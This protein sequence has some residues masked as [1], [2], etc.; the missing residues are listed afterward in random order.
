MT[1]NILPS[2][3]FKPAQPLGFGK[4]LRSLAVAT[5]R[6]IVAL[7]SALRRPQHHQRR[8]SLVEEANE[9]RDYASQFQRQDPAF[10]ADLMA[11]ADRHEL[12][13]KA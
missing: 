6:V 12:A 2:H 9:L 5:T 7:M 8:L 10:A 1:S 13:G 4:A 11:A 3:S